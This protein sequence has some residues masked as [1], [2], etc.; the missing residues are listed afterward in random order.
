M[1]GQDILNKYLKRF[2]DTSI[3]DQKQY[4]N[5]A[6]IN[7]AQDAPWSKKTV[8][9]NLTAG[10]SEYALAVTSHRIW[11]VSYLASATNVVELS[12][13]SQ[14]ELDLYNSGWR[15]Q[16]NGTPNWFYFD[17]TDSLSG[18][19]GLYPKP[20]TTT[21]AGYP[22]VQAVVTNIVVFS[23]LSEVWPYSPETAD[24][25]ADMM[26][27]LRA[28]DVDQASIP[29]WQMIA[30]KSKAD[31]AMRLLNRNAGAPPTIEPVVKIASNWRSRQ[32]R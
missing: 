27:L 25:V 22:V 23:T 28:K 1:T 30:D 5:D 4:L 13:T 18:V 19:L 9:V 16:T 24:M 11:S 2:P 7:I 15:Y 10:T 14:D 17:S 29:E 32:G 21:N 6:V 8:S 26:C 31:S 20:D 3:A 12:P